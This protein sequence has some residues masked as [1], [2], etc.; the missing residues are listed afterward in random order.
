MA[1]PSLYLETTV[2]GHLAARQHSDISV[3]ARQLASRAWWDARSNYDLFVSQIVID[4]CA[5]MNAPLE[6]HSPRRNDLT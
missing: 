2:I 4:E 5:A 6:T 1:K 3:A